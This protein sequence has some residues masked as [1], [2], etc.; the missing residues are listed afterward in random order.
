MRHRQRDGVECLQAVVTPEP[1]RV[2]MGQS[3]NL[4]CS[5]SEAAGAAFPNGAAGGCERQVSKIRKPRAV[6]V[7]VWPVILRS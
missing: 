7:A 3:I 1:L 4:Q 5:G 6:N 2:I